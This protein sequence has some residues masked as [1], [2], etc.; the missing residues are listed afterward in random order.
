MVSLVGHAAT[1][2]GQPTCRGFLGYL[3]AQTRQ[4][5][6]WPVRLE[7]LELRD[8]P[9]VRAGARFRQPTVTDDDPGS[10]DAAAGRE[11]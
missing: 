2:N 11:P 8:R 6:Q 4:R 3:A 10:C 1:D 5:D 7:A 9:A